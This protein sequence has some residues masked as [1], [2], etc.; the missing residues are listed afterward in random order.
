MKKDKSELIFKPQPVSQ[1]GRKRVLYIPVDT[2]MNTIQSALRTRAIKEKR[3]PYGHLFL[4]KNQVALST[5][6]GAPLAVIGLERLI[7]SGAEEIL[8]LGFCGALDKNAKIA[9]PVIITQASSEEGTSRHYFPRKRIFRPSSSLR[10]EL[11]LT[12]GAK[13]LPYST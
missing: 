2:P 4:L 9:D 3:E 11:E 6:I 5:S 8:I 7:A 12:L 1:F 10:K 13:R